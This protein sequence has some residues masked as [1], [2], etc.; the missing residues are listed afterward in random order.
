MLLRPRLL[1]SLPHTL[2]SATPARPAL[3]RVAHA[4]GYSASWVP[5]ACACPPPGG[6]LAGGLYAV[7]VSNCAC[8]YTA[9]LTRGARSDGLTVPLTRKET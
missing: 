1:H 9:A 6:V 2:W 5:A 4:A 3:M 7:T 8:A